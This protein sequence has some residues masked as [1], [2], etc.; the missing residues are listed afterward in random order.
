MKFFKQYF[1]VLTGVWGFEYFFFPLLNF[2]LEFGKMKNFIKE[3]Q[4]ML[5]PRRILSSATN[6]GSFVNFA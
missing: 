5:F 3:I 2:H 4:K 1:L 6:P